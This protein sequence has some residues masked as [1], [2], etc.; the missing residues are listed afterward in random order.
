MNPNEELKPGESGPRRQTQEPSDI[1]A[2]NAEATK[3]AMQLGVSSMSESETSSSLMG[4]NTSRPFSPHDN[5]RFAAGTTTSPPSGFHAMA[6]DGTASGVGLLPAI[7][8]R[9]YSPPPQPETPS[10]KSHETCDED[11]QTVPE[12]F[13]SHGQKA[14]YYDGPYVVHHRHDGIR[15]TKR[16]CKYKRNQT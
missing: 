14:P 3:L 5:K 8:R 15:M 16:W 9:N 11:N 2:A 1:V 13:D 6:S 12:Y 10:N 4:P 7:P